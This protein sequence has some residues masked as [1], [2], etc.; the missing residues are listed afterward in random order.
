MTI[1]SDW[2]QAQLDML[3]A[4]PFGA[5]VVDSRHWPWFCMGAVHYGEAT[6]NVWALPG[7]ADLSTSRRLATFGPFT[8]LRE[9]SEISPPE[10][11]VWGGGRVIA[12]LSW[13]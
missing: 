13:P 11:P 9:D 10:S 12:G 8:I 6:T 4:L 7:C 2:M 5:I 1:R 3:D